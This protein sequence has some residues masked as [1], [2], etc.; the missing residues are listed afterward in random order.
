MTVKTRNRAQV[1]RGFRLKLLDPEISRR[2]ACQQFRNGFLEDG[3]NEAGRDF[4]QGREDE[5]P[6]VKSWMR[7]FQTLFLDDFLTEEEQIQVDHP[8]SPALLSHTAHVLFDG[9]EKC[10]QLPGAY[11]AFERENGVDEGRLLDGP[12]RL[13]AIQGRCG[14]KFY[15]RA[16]LQRILRLLNLANRLAEV[17]AR[18]DEG[19]RIQAQ[20][21]AFSILS[22]ASLSLASGTVRAKRIYPSPEGPKPFPGV[23][24]TPQFLKT[25]A[26]NSLEVKPSGHRTQT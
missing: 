5:A 6:L 21:P 20:K 23:V 10:E 17:R 15:A 3:M 24:T 13:R 18:A 25:C 22:K 14:E 26:V 12:H 1:S 11:A 4:G 8:G 16:F 7:H 9:Q 19:A 2:K